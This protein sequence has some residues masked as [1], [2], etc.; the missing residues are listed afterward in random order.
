MTEVKNDYISGFKGSFDY[1]TISG[2]AEHLREVAGER[3][4]GCPSDANYDPELLCL[5]TDAAEA[6][7]KLNLSR[8]FEKANYLRAMST[9]ES[10]SF[11]IAELESEIEQF[12]PDSMT[13]F[14]GC[15]TVPDDVHPDRLAGIREILHAVI[16][17]GA[18]PLE[19]KEHERNKKNV[20]L[21]KKALSKLKERFGS[22][23]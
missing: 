11:E 18:G 6:L 23:K 7:E 12:A 22:E 17:N 15:F 20:L 19:D 3:T 4:S 21:A 16:D 5:L 2:L 13:D 14:S 1:N 8:N 9:V 10:R